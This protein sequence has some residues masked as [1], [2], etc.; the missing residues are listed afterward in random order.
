MRVRIDYFFTRDDI[1]RRTWV[2]KIIRVF[3]T[4]RQSIYLL[5]IYSFCNALTDKQKYNLEIFKCNQTSGMSHVYIS[6]NLY[7]I[8]YKAIWVL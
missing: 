5:M 1:E 3:I 6:F 2:H 8:N 7:G 4:I